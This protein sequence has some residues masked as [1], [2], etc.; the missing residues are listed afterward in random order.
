[1]TTVNT[2]AWSISSRRKGS[3]HGPWLPPLLPSQRALSEPETHREH[4]Q[5]Y[6]RGAFRTTPAP[7]GTFYRVVA[8]H[9]P[10]QLTSK[11]HGISTP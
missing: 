1:M 6:T 4:R 7:P 11:T 5:L 9:M 10:T 3:A 2:R 8:S